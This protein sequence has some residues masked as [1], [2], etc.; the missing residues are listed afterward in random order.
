[1]RSWILAILLVALGCDDGGFAA[2][3]AGGAADGVPADG[4]R[5]PDDGALP[6]PPRP[7]AA[8]SLDAQ[9]RDAAGG[10]DGSTCRP[11]AAF[12]VEAIEAFWWAGTPPPSHRLALALTDTAC[13]PL[14]AESDARWLEALIDPAG[15]V[16]LTVDPTELLSG[17]HTAT[18]TIRTGDATLATLTYRLGLLRRPPGGGHPKV[19]VVGAD[20]VRAD[21][22]AVA[23]TP[24]LDRWTERAAWTRAASTQRTGATL[25]GPG[26]ASVLTGVEPAHHGVDS[27]D[28]LAEHDPRWP[29]FLRR[30]HDLGFGTA[31]AC[32]WIPLLLSLIEPGATDW[33]SVGDQALVG[34][35]MADQIRTAD[36]DVHFVHLDDPDHAGHASGYAINNPEYIDAIQRV[37]DEVGRLFAA[38]LDRPTVGVEDWLFIFTTDHGGRGLAH[39]PQDAEH[40][41]IPLIIAGAAT[42][43]GRLGAGASHTMVHATVMAH[44]GYPARPDWALDGAAAGLAAETACFDHLDDDGDAATD[45]ADP[46]CA[47]ACGGACPGVAPLPPTCPTAD[48]GEALGAG[49]AQGDTTGGEARMV[50]PCGGWGPEQSFQW[51]APAADT[52]AFDTVGS[53]YD[54][55]LYLRDGCAGAPLDCNAEIFGNPRDDVPIQR[56]SRVSR[57]LEAGAEIT[58]VVDGEGVTPEGAFVLN[59][60]GLGA[61]CGDADLGSAV[62]PGVAEGDN[63]AAPTRYAAD[64]ATTARDRT[65]R[66]QAPAAGRWR[67]DTAGSEHDTV[68]WILGATC[69]GPALACNDDAGGLQSQVEVELVA[70]QAIIVAVAGFRGRAGHWVLNIT[71]VD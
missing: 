46:D 43:P 54:T 47:C 56:V 57:A 45:C 22:F 49:V 60:W 21:A 28:D 3:D 42:D 12:E 40:Q 10:T 16:R 50:G 1:M 63:D 48:L 41:T 5:P 64:C 37:D 15:A 34:R 29:T 6:D 14:R 17:R 35:V 33:Q 66:W 30:A 2:A 39:G 36:H 18:V 67:F 20:G 11:T 25:S 4:A 61:E 8:A 62:G 65:L 52:Y 32:Q 26:W 59:I 44:L 24:N 53:A 68:L 38:V 9:R 71:R 51:R 23:A 58:V 70:G 27:N 55:V 7:D 19:L 69:L 31:A 13:A